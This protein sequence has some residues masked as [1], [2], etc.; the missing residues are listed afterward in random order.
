MVRGPADPKGR[1]VSGRS[2]RV[3][4]IVH[5]SRTG[6]SGPVVDT[7]GRWNQPP[8]GY[9][10][11]GDDSED[12]FELW[13]YPADELVL[14]S[15]A[16]GDVFVAPLDLDF[17]AAAWQ[18][19]DVGSIV[20]QVDLSI[21]EPTEQQGATWA[22]LTTLNVG[23]H[24]YQL[25]ATVTADDVVS[26]VWGDD[27]AIRVRRPVRRRWWHVRQRYDVQDIPMIRLW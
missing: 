15:P 13:Q 24:L 12:S 4:D 6:V 14:I 11:F 23:G 1:R 3:G 22:A 9:V 21:F 19:A 5:H 8:P 20:E 16:Q 26:I 17:D 10:L 18:V 27:P 2:F 25:D 7:T